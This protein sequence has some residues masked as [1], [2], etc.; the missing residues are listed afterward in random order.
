MKIRALCVAVVAVGLL[1]TAAGAFQATRVCT[2]ENGRKVRIDDNACRAVGATPSPSPQPT[3]S[4]LDCDPIGGQQKFA[5]GQERMFCFTVGPGST[6][7]AIEATS[8]AN[9][10]CAYFQLELTEPSGRK[11][12]VDGASYPIMG[13]SEP[14]VVGGKYYFWVS[15]LWLGEQP[16]CDTYVLTVR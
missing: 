6:F 10:G 16:G 5:V 8:P 4:P 12:L 7:V 3:V 13:S 9:V 2:L 15:P 11:T 1:F 14:R